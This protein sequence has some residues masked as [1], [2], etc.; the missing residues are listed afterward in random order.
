MLSVDRSVSGRARTLNWHG[1]TGIWLLAGLL[2]LSA[3][4]I[5]WSTY[6]GAHVTDIRTALSWQRPQLDTVLPV[7]GGRD[8]VAID[9]DAVLAAAA[10][11]GVHVP[12]EVTLPTGAGQAV[13]VTEIEKPYRLTTN[14]ASVDPD[15]LTVSSQVDFW[16]DYSLVA[17]LAD[18]GIRAHMGL[19]FGLLNQFVLLGVAVGLLTVIVRG[20]RMWW[21]RRPTRGSDWAVGR[22]PMRGGVRRLHPLAIAAL[23][24]IAA[25]VGWFLPLLGISL[26]AFLIVDVVIAMV[27]RRRPSVAKREVDA[28]V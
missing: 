10:S 5:T 6:A 3:T 24:V 19:L 28:D 13:V 15:S 22:P 20:Y 25:G 8:P 1:A 9:F 17:K 7:D 23:A 11:V 27:K 18:W 2:F 21:Q 26:A 12:L 4:G 14:A 16:R